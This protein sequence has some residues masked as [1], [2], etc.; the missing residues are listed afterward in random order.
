MSFSKKVAIVTGSSQGIGKAIAVLLSQN[1]AAVILNGRNQEKLNIVEEEIKAYNSDV[2]SFCGYVSDEK[3]AENLI[4]FALEKFGKIDILVNNVGISMRGDFAD[5]D[6]DVF[7]K[8]FTTNVMGKI[9]PTK[10]AI[11]ALRKTKGSIIFISS[12]AGI[13]GLPTLSA[14]SA[15]KMA[16]KSF[17]D[18]IRTEEVSH[19]LHVGL[20]YVAITE[21]EK[22]KTTIGQ[23]GQEVILNTRANKKVQ[24]TKQVAEAVLQNLKTKKNISILSGLGVVNYYM[25]KFFPR[26]VDKI[27]LANL[28]KF[29]SEGK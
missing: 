12:L 2:C 3:V 29:K 24:T 21:I 13:R 16:L 11:P 5:L 25:Q 27:I 15:S 8:V 1:G 10:F 22:N 7:K 18:S 9:F 19:K 14:Y 4:L 23:N 6:P 26:L 20:I 17:A 28:A